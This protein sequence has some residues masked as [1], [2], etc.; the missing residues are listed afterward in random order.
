[1]GLQLFSGR[2]FFLGFLSVLLACVVV[3]LHSFGVSVCSFFA[4]TDQLGLIFRLLSVVLGCSLLYCRGYSGGSSLSSGC[5]LLRIIFSV[6]CCKASN[7][8]LF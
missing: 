5:V 4:H 1:M 3:F 8:F 7:A 6:I 2:Y